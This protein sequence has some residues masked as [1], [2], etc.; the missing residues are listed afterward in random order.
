VLFCKFP[1]PP[2]CFFTPLVSR[3][4]FCRVKAFL[5][6]PRSSSDASDMSCFLPPNRF[7]AY[8]DV[9]PSSWISTRSFFLNRFLL[10]VFLVFPKGPFFCLFET[11]LFFTELLLRCVFCP[12]LRLR[13]FFF[14]VFFSLSFAF[15]SQFTTFS[16]CMNTSLP[17]EFYCIA[18]LP[19]SQPDTFFSAPLQNGNF[20]TLVASE[21]WPFPHLRPFPGTI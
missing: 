5:P 19:L 9:L 10:S 1:P 21:D 13:F 2:F 7:L 3:E 6:H 16:F 15:P 11:F 8:P 4:R 20:F 14:P 17:L 12:W 18:G